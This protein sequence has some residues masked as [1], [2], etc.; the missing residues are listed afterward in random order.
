M[1]LEVLC[2]KSHFSK[3]GKQTKDFK[4]Q[5]ENIIFE[6]IN[7]IIGELFISKIKIA[8]LSQHLKTKMAKIGNLRMILI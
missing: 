2:F 6:R 3:C 4:G 5:K 8:K 7:G 1:T